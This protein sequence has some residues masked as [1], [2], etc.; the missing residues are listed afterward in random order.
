MGSSMKCLLI[1]IMGCNYIVNALPQK[2]S[3]IQ[4]T[5]DKWLDVVDLKTEI[6]NDVFTFSDF[7]STIVWT[8][9]QKDTV[10]V[11]NMKLFKG[12][13]MAKLTEATPDDIPRKRLVDYANNWYFLFAVS[14]YIHINGQPWQPKFSTLLFKTNEVTICTFDIRD[15]IHVKEIG[16]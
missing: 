5:I 15:P 1:I 12:S 14:T 11:L 8:E 13:P 10:L 4:S 6:G 9:Q 16:K 7:K 2:E 3:N